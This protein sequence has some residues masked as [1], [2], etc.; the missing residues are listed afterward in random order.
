LPSDAELNKMMNFMEKAWRRLAE[1][2]VTLQK[3]MLNKN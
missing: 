2:I 3:D 1:M